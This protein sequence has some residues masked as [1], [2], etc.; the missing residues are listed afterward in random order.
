MSIAPGVCLQ[1]SSSHSLPV[2]CLGECHC[3][4][5][6]V[7][8]RQ[9]FYSVLCSQ[10]VSQGLGYS[11]LLHFTE[12]TTVILTDFFTY[13]F[14]F[15]FLCFSYWLF[16][17]FPHDSAIWAGLCGAALSVSRDLAG[18]ALLGLE[19]RSKTVLFIVLFTVTST[20]PWMNEWMGY[21]YSGSLEDNNNRQ[22]RHTFYFI[23]ITT[24]WE[25]IIITLS[26]VKKLK[27]RDVR[28]LVQVVQGNSSM[29]GD[30]WDRS[31]SSLPQPWLTSLEM[32]FRW[33]LGSVRI[34]SSWLQTVVCW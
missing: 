18:M 1:C 10:P 28:W 12:W 4:W 14:S 6:W 34:S 22:L 7:L 20:H 15:L 31:P 11:C 3:H 27:F 9:A 17:L 2:V 30:H 32:E 24:L 23:L 19:D 5:M 29:K 33:L 25:Y 26:Q 16:Q 8:W 13:C 21:C